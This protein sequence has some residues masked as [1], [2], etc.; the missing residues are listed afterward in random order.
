MT[1]AALEGA[2]VGAGFTPE[3]EFGEWPQT[4]S[5]SAECLSRLLLQASHASRH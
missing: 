4:N 5:A 3:A 1:L 2:T